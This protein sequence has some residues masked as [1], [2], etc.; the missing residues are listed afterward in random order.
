MNPN[1]VFE[2]FMFVPLKH[3]TLSVVHFILLPLFFDLGEHDYDSTAMLT[4]PWGF[5]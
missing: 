2:D 3:K 5:T 4:A 1:K